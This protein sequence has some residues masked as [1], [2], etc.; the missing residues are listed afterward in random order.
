MIEGDLRRRREQEILEHFG[1]YFEEL[2]ILQEN[3]KFLEVILK[4]IDQL[5]VFVSFLTEF[6]H[7]YHQLACRFSHTKFYTRNKEVIDG[8]CIPSHTDA[9][10]T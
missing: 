9:T 8:N 7:R 4:I 10:I 2:G 3:E 6:D 1:C 5:I